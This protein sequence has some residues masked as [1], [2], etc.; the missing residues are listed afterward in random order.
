M[1]GYESMPWSSLPSKGGPT[2]KKAKADRLTRLA[3]GKPAIIGLLRRLMP[4]ITTVGPTHRA[5]VELVTG[6]DHPI[7]VDL[8]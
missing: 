2:P 7:E 6:L 8:S 4:V 1:V 5:M 3:R